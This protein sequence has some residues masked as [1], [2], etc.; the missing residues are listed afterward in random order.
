MEHNIYIDIINRV[1]FYK[2]QIRI[3]LAPNEKFVSYLACCLL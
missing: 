2:E 3:L 1:S